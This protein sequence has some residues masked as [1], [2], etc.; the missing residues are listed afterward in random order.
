LPYAVK[1][2]ELGVLR[3][4]KERPGNRYVLPDR[5]PDRLGVFILKVIKDLLSLAHRTPQYDVGKVM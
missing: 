1:F 3:H 4:P 2:L 5:I